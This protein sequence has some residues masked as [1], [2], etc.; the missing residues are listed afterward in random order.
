MKG[1][2]LNVFSCFTSIVNPKIVVKF[3]IPV[4]FPDNNIITGNKCISRAEIPD[5]G[6]SWIAQFYDSCVSIS[7]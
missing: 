7:I 3:R 6:I 4:E 2:N 1:F 5:F